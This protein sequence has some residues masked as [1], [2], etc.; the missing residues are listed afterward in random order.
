[1]VVLVKLVLLCL[2]LMRLFTIPILL[3]QIPILQ[4]PLT[5]FLVPKFLLPIQL[6]ILVIFVQ[7]SSGHGS[8]GQNSDQNSGAM[9]PEIQIIGSNSVAPV[10]F[11]MSEVADGPSVDADDLSIDEI[12]ALRKLLSPANV[13]RI[14]T[15]SLPG[16]QSLKSKAAFGVKSKGK[17]KK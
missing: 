12:R 3:L 9:D 10:D 8:S 6:Q 11:Q 16:D 17:K 1:M 7:N 14:G 15:G 4:S 13:R 5:P 2:I